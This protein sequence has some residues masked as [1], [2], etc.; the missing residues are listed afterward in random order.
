MAHTL[1]IKHPQP[2][3]SSLWSDIVF[4]WSGIRCD[5]SLNTVGRSILSA[6]NWI[7]KT[8]HENTLM[9]FSKLKCKTETLNTFYCS[10]N[11][12]K[13]FLLLVIV[14]LTWQKNILA[15]C[16]WEHWLVQTLWK[17]D[18]YRFSNLK[19]MLQDCK[20]CIIPGGATYVELLSKQ[21]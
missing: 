9:Q 2:D 21:N 19:T 6:D 5:I 14:Y 15:Q 3:G 18:S 10:S 4:L 7:R 20:I 17:T 1:H 11:C 13:F 16:S 8:N 12:Q